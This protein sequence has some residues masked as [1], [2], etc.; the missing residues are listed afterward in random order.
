MVLGVFVFVADV[1]AGLLWSFVFFVDALLELAAATVV[2]AAVVY[3]CYWGLKSRLRSEDTT[4]SSGASPQVDVD[5]DEELTAVTDD[6]TQDPVERLTEQY[7]QGELTEAEF[8]A[9]LERELDESGRT[10]LETEF[11]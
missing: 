3:L 11:E 10:G 7:K 5:V 4:A 8:E 2:F 6:V 1:V 9:R